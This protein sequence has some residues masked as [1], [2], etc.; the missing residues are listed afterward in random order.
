MRPRAFFFENVRGLARPSFR[1]YFDYILLRLQAPHLTP[2]PDQ[3]WREHRAEL[4]REIERQPQQSRY[5]VSW[6]L[7]NAADYGVPQMRWRIVIVGFRADLHIRWHFPEATHS[8]KA[9]VAAQ[10]G[11]SYWQEHGIKPPEPN[12]T[13][14]LAPGDG[15]KRWRTLRDALK[16]LPEP[17]DGHEHPDFHNHVGIPGARLYNGHSGSD[18]DWPAKSVKA[19]VHGCPGGEHILVRH[20]GSYR[21]WTVRETARV[22]GFPDSHRF[23][24]PRSEAMRQIGNAVP[25]PLAQLIAERIAK[26]LH[27]TVHALED[28]SP[29]EAPRPGGNQPDDGGGPESRLES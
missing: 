11:G 13:P 19:G 25:V 23:E 29:T 17:V 21:Y 28:R 9:L 12:R 22:Q 16:G 26:E 20:D 10:E 2:K 18:L 27:A 8:K 24:G 4:L 5:E 1:P 14:C 7:V 3:D 6:K 15:L